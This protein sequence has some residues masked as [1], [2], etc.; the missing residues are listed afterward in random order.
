M[1]FVKITSAISI[2]AF[3]ASLAVAQ[4][5]DKLSIGDSPLDF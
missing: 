1:L 2:V 3:L 4:Q 5:W